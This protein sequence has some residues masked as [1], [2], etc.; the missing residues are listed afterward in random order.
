MSVPFLSSWDQVRLFLALMRARSLAGAGKRVQLDASNVSRRLV[1]LEAEMGIPLFDRTR[2]GLVPTSAAENLLP[3][4][5]EVELGMAR[6]AAAGAPV[7]TAV[8]GV[9]RVTAPPGVADTFVAPLLTDRHARHPRL[10]IELDASVGYA[11]LTR[12]E[13]DLA[14]RT[15]RPERGELLVAQLVATRERPMASAEYARD[16][17]RLAAFEDARWV[18]WGDELAHLPG[19][20]WLRTHAPSVV[21][22]LRSN[23]FSSVLAA[24]RAGLGVAVLPEPYLR[25]G[26]VPIAHGKALSGAWATL[27]STELWLV[28]HRALRHVP[29]VASVWE[30]LSEKLGAFALDGVRPRRRASGGRR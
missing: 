7:E 15:V 3:H 10:S 25:T 16:V 22:V 11:D 2:G 24:T 9:V 28:A 4:A 1:R 14:L 5:E 23:H 19:P 26:L 12:R 20:R 21:P 27:P 30:F 13:A 8:E 6:F 17:G 18:A 29:R